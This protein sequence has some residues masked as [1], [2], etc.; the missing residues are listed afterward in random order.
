MLNN[1]DEKPI[2]KKWKN[3]LAFYPKLNIYFLK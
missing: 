3:H 2:V 1:S